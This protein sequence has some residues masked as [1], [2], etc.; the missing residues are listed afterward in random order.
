MKIKFFQNCF[1]HE[2]LTMSAKPNDSSEAYK[3]LNNLSENPFAA[4][5]PSLQHAEEYIKS[6]K[7]GFAIERTGGKASNEFGEEH[8]SALFAQQISNEWQDKAQIINEFLQR[9]FLFTVISGNHCSLVFTICDLN[10]V[11]KI[12]E[13][14]LVLVSIFITVNELDKSVCYD[15]IRYG[16]MPKLTE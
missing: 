12:I 6:A 3:D 10:M 15:T 13:Y 14:N 16:I 11:F 1:P 8:Q 9:A 5:F 7:A 2:P 4:L